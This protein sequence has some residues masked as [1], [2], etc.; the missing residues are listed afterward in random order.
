MNAISSSQATGGDSN[1]LTNFQSSRLGR[2]SLDLRASADISLVTADGDKIT[3][4]ANSS[5][6]AI[7]ETYNYRGRI[8]GQAIAARGEESQLTTSSGFAVTVDGTLDDEELAD[9]NKLLDMIA[10]VSEDFFSGNTQDGLKHLAEFDNLD[11]IASFEATLSY[12]REISVLT[13]SQSTRMAP[14]RSLG[15]SDSEPATPS[16]RFYAADTFIE[17]LAR[18]AEQLNSEEGQEKIPKRFVELFKKLLLQ[19]PLDPQEENLAERIQSEHLKRSL[20][21]H[22]DTPALEVS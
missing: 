20:G 4:S 21:D 22:T 18:A 19:L 13:T 7:L 11:A 10:S 9:I 2:G 5:T 3:L 8:Q 12:S 17:Q 16:T 1:A 6:Q 15:Q 14:A